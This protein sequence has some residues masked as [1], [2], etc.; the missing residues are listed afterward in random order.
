MRIFRMVNPPGVPQSATST[1]DRFAGFVTVAGVVGASLMSSSAMGQQ[2][3]ASSSSDT[4]ELQEI[5][6]TG[7]MIKRVNA[8]TA[9]AVTIV[10]MDSLKDL[11][12]TNVE[13]A[14]SLLTS[15][16]ATITTASNVATFNGGASVAALRGLRATETLVLLDGQR[17]ANNV[18]L[19]TGVDL[20]TIPFAAI[21]HIEVLREG[22]SSLYGS[23]AIAGVINFI[24][25][26]NLEGGEV[27]LQ[28]S[29]PEH[30]GGSSDNAD[31]TYG[32]GNLASD[33]YNLMVTGNFT[34]Q[35][36]LT[37]GQRPFASTGYNPALGLA[38][39]N[40]PTGP[41]PGSYTDANSNL[42]QTGY[43]ACA[44]NPHLVA[45][46]GSCEYLY[47]AAV[48]LIPEQS[49][50]SGLIAFT[51]TLPA[52]NTLS[53]QYFYA[54]SDLTLWS[55]PQEYSFT[56]LP[57]SPYYPTAANSS[58]YGG[59]ANCVLPGTTTPTG[60]ALGGS[61]TAGWTDPNNNRYFGNINTEQRALVTFSGEN[62]GWD[63]ST[64]F[65]WSANKGTQQVRGGEANY[66]IIAPG[67]VIS[68][69]INPFGPQSA[70]GQSLINSAYTNGNLE[71]GT[72]S[73]YD[74]NGH[75]S[76]P[77]GDLFNA[78]RP[79]QFAVGFDYKDEQI[80]DVPTQLA[81]TLYTATYFPPN[82]VT[83]SRVS[84]AAYLELNVPVTSQLEFTGS[85]RQDRYSDF[86]TTNNA[87]VSFAY[88]PFSILK[89]RGAASTG[90]RAPTLVEEYSPQVFGAV[91]GTMN[92]P[93]CA[94]GNYNTVF[95]KLNCSSQGL[96]LSGGNPDL[97]PET[98]Q[99]FDIGFVVQP[100]SNLDVT[101]DY[102]RINLKNQIQALPG[103]T[104][105]SNPTTFSNDYVLN[106]AGTLT[107]APYANI[108]CPTPKAATCGYIVQT[109]QNTGTVVTDGF[110]LSANYLLDTDFGK[111]HVS[112]EGT[113]VTGYRLEEYPGG[114][115]LN[116]VGQ[117]NQGNQPVIRYQQELMLDWTLANWGAGLNNHFLEHYTDY[118]PDAAGNLL[119]VG[120][121]SI[122]NGYV[123]YKPIPALKLLV[124]INNLADT[125]PP[126][127][128]QT[129][130]WQSGYNP[131]FSSPL[132]RTFYGRVTFDF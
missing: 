38:N 77:L 61:I 53:I 116:L 128:N 18:A 59:A 5:V 74:L 4:P 33:G 68:N 15:N 108:D 107:P 96:S 100:M 117:F 97:K 48:D 41:W 101:L 22:A 80:T 10:K 118:L 46:N 57:S 106:S 45:L 131:V 51:K 32:I 83:G 130:N 127:S 14:L 115:E 69:L 72:L 70:A 114:P 102:Y 111:F 82:L 66:A 7:S 54:R 27:N 44:G 17:L 75:A 23:D 92:G 67:G 93:G 20:N 126:F 42:W 6:V 12:V 84:E 39:I 29:H 95:S 89:F 78:G 11:G 103:S 76:H 119:T 105:Y 62:G 35:K 30:P 88:Q 3:P 25:K 123:S 71:V 43:P 34:Q 49:T 8:E 87:K 125:N 85:D 56:M 31:L 52:N 91:F 122:W 55:G 79:A 47:S 36:E 63:Y 121:Y 110:D 19:G 28:Y 90:F 58:C 9:E 50:E 1:L 113:F 60:P 98:S 99:N 132:G 94:S 64:A 124:G 65:D 120:N 81:T 109:D 24:T 21:D 26:K 2:A 73:L 13:Q 40:G 112:L 37:P 104:I 86:G 129:Q 16:N